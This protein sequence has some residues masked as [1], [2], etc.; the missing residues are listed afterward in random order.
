MNPLDTLK[1]I[2]HRAYLAQRQLKLYRAARS[3][4]QSADFK[5]RYASLDRTFT[6]PPLP[7]VQGIWGIAMVKNEADIIELAVK[8][9]LDQG[10]DRL[11]I[12][13]NGSTDKTLDILHG[14]AQS[15]PISVGT[16]A[17]PAYYQSEKM[18]W[19]ADRAKEHGATWIIPFDADEFWFGTRLGLAQE[20]AQAKAPILEAPIYNQ[21]P[22]PGGGWK[23]DPVPH[24]EAKICFKPNR[25]YVIS[26]GNHSLVGP[27]KISKN[28]TA[29]LHRPWRSFDQFERKIR[30][31]AASLNLTD[32][33]EELGYHWRTLG[34]A[35]SDEL[36][37]VWSRLITGKKVEEDIAWKPSGKL[38]P[39]TEPL[40]SRWEELLP[41]ISVL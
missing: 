31:G 36:Q 32:L 7:R 19:L 37:G 8:H 5:A 40:P 35:S 23:L 21:F 12:V 30:Q 16:D 9:L 24:R 2:K 38:I 18:T 3:L 11:L 28:K 1:H 29:I 4:R 22:Q 41:Q 39:L 20:L 10:V 15:Y 6:L 34:F 25:P 27:G 13:D 33:P 26:M 14:L 17:E